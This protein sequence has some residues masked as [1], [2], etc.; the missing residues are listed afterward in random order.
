MMIRSA[1]PASPNL[2]EI[3]VPAPTPRMGAPWRTVS[4]SLAS[5]CSRED[6]H[7]P[8]Q[9]AQKLRDHAGGELGVVDVCVH[10]DDL[11]LVSVP[12]EGF[13]QRGVRFRIIKRLPGR[14]DRPRNPPPAPT[15]HTS[16][17]PPAALS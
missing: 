12:A 14:I 9:H 3:P 17:P 10:L 6:I 16:P 1:P 7:A 15:T 8:V 4:R 13:E 2:A 11:H 5:D